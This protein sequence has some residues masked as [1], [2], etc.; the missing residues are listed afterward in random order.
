MPDFSDDIEKIKLTLGADKLCEII[1]NGDDGFYLVMSMEKL[2]GSN[3][4]ILTEVG[5]NNINGAW[6]FIG[7]YN[8]TPVNTKIWLPEAIKTIFDIF[9]ENIY[10]YR[11]F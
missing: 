6:Y 5:N 10:F 7:D 9:P 8:G 11:D 3:Q 4:L 1:A 2:P